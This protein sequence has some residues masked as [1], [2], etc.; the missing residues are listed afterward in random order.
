MPW[1]N[2]FNRWRR[3]PKGVDHS[4]SDLGDTS[5]LLSKRLVQLKQ[6]LERIRT[7]L[8]AAGNQSLPDETRSMLMIL[9]ESIEGDLAIGE[10]S[11]LLRT[12]S[13]AFLE[14]RVVKLEG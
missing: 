2:W 14:L 6:R 8:G 10:R 9:L 11:G 4:G 3:A 13:I 5:A 7:D 1:S 12:E